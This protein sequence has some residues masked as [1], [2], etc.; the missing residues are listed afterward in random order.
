MTISWKKSLNK[1]DYS[2]DNLEEYIIKV[3]DIEK[4]EIK[5]IP[6][7]KSTPIPVTDAEGKLE[8]EI[9]DLKPHT[10]YSISV[11]E[12]FASDIKTGFSDIIQAKT[13]FVCDCNKIG[14]IGGKNTCEDE[15][16]HCKKPYTGA[17]CQKCEAGYYDTDQ[18]EKTANCTSM[19]HYCFVLQLGTIH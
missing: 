14:T 19:Y 1:A 9:P 17:F 11:G 16:C 6:V 12:S 15:Q 7:P 4:N 8:Y 10:I 13:K 18:H 5:V 2:F 3:K